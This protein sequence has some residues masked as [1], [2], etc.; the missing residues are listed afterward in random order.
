MKNSHL[1]NYKL[2]AGQEDELLKHKMLMLPWEQS[3]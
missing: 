1:T 2:K 3:I